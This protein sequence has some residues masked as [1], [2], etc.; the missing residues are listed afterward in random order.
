MTLFKITYFLTNESLILLEEDRDVSFLPFVQQIKNI[1]IRDVLYFVTKTAFLPE[2][3]ELF[4]H[5]QE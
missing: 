2:S 3:N 5:L 4:I 1:E